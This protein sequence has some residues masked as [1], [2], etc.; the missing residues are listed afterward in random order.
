MA[1]PTAN[2]FLFNLISVKR[3][4]IFIIV[5]FIYHGPLITSNIKSHAIV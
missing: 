2:L 5:L 4:L 1:A 3:K